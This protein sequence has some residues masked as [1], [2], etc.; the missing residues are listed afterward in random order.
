MRA[1]T[2]R[3]NKGRRAGQGGRGPP[4]GAATVMARGPSRRISANLHKVEV[5]SRL[6]RRGPSHRVAFVGCTGKV[7]CVGRRRT[8]GELRRNA[9][10]PAILMSST[11][12][13]PPPDMQV[14]SMVDE[15]EGEWKHLATYASLHK[16][17]WE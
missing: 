15:E 10:F 4:R 3:P 2:D 14:S 6:Y 16:W 1:T 13:P 12:R 17:K 11:A 7:H 9:P 8:A 5:C